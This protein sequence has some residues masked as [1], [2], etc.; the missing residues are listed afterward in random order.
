M[1]TSM[2]R[3]PAQATISERYHEAAR[4]RLV[5]RQPVASSSRPAV[6]QVRLA[7][8]AAAL[9]A[10]AMLLVSIPALSSA[11]AAATSASMP[12]PTPAPAPSLVR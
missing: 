5:R 2:T 12:S 10:L 8:P 6:G 7:G 4:A 1:T 11:P 9:A 3:S